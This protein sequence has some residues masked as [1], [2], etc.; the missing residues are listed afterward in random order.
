VPVYVSDISKLRNIG[1]WAPEV[2]LE[3]TVGGMVRSFLDDPEL[4]DFL[5]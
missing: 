2:N 3:S 5:E 1:A 4:L